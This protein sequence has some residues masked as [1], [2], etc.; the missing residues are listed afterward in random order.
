MDRTKQVVSKILNVL[1]QDRVSAE[2]K[3]ELDMEL[4]GVREWAVQQQKL[5]AEKVRLLLTPK[6][7]KSKWKDYKQKRGW[8]TKIDQGHGEGEEEW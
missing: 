5:R 7:L 6:E 8:A 1:R 2:L 3:M 4:Q